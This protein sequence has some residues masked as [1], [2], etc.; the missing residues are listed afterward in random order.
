MQL[1]DKS[2]H[3][4]QELPPEEK[5]HLIYISGQLGLD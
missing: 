3:V 5:S 4:W 1:I 2:L